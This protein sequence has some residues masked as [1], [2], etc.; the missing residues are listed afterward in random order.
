M[1]SE[2]CW[3][4]VGDCIWDRDCVRIGIG[5]ATRVRI[6]IG[7]GYCSWD[8]DWIGSEFGIGIEAGV[9]DRGVVGK[10]R[11]PREEVGTSV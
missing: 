1:G 5:I 7:L 3:I 2:L 11:E 10:G 6:E 8:R 4:G 9:G